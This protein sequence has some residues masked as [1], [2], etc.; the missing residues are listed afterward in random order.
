MDIDVRFIGSKVKEEKDFFVSRLTGFPRYIF[1]HFISEVEM[2]IDNKDYI[3]TPGTCIIYTPPYPQYYKAKGEWLNHDWIE[4]KCND[5]SIFDLLM[6]P[7]NHPFSTTI[8]KFI[9]SQVASMAEINK[10]D[11]FYKNVELTAKI[12]E[13]F[14]A[15]SKNIHNKYQSMNKKNQQNISETFEQIRLSIY[16]NPLKTSISKIAKDA[17]YTQSHFCATYKKI[18]NVSPLEDLDKS[19]ILYVKDAFSHKLKTAIIAEEL[20]FSSLEYFYMWFKKHFGMT[21]LEFQKLIENDT[22]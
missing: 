1:I 19:R 8:S 4:F 13:L 9:S 3:L 10:G 17:G 2:V 15:I 21:T 20:G 12:Y 11:L 6:I 7:L 18:F 22:N 14:I 16:Q 5:E